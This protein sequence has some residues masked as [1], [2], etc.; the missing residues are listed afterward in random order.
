MILLSF[1]LFFLLLL[2]GMDIALAMIAAAIVGMMLHGGID[3]VVSAM[4]LVTS[5][6]SAALIT[7]PLFVLA[8]EVMSRGG[9][10]LRLVA[11]S[12]AMIGHF[13]GS[14][15]QV[16]I[17]TNLIM[18]GIS[19]SAVADAAATGGMLIP[20]M[21]KAGYKPGYPSAVIAAGA[22][23]GP[24]IPPSIPL[25]VYA[26]LANVSIAR[27]FIAA[28]V[29]GLILAA[30]Y[31]VI[32]AL[33]A[34]RRNYGAEPRATWRER[35]RVTRTSI[36]AL[37][38][39]VLIIVGVR[40]GLFT[41][42]EAA[43]VICLY[44]LVVCLFIYRDIGIRH[45]PKVLYDAGRTSGIVLFLLAASGPFTWLMNE[46]RVA[47]TITGSILAISTDPTVVLLI[48]AGFLFV[49]GTVLEPLPA[50]VMFLP[51]LLPIQAQVG[52]D[53]IQF[54]M[55]VSLNL[56]LGMVTPP[57]GML[58]FV[59]SA[60]GRERIDAIVWESVPFVLW[61]LVLIILIIIFPSIVTWLPSIAF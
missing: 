19:G 12:S 21:K 36:W 25:V 13:R 52:I 22:M 8:S 2:A 33:I 61:M 49:I 39:P 53:E 26:V 28:I 7:V 20:A 43:G 29:P 6:D 4:T 10:L 38:M 48:I 3:P 45:M 57:V 56:M 30:G 9:M 11:W 17:T 59:V 37:L 41:D 55:V 47:E 18:A 44:A 50:M 15:S 40:S 42:S 1:G 34:R 23:L 24:I 35:A 46:T 14:L 60:V 58:L 32:C 5:I 16:A 54:A 31:M 27:L 51:T